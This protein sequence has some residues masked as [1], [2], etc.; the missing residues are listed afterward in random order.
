MLVIMSDEVVGTSTHGFYPPVTRAW[1]R[2]ASTID[3]VFQF[4]GAT[5]AASAMAETRWLPQG[6]TEMIGLSWL[7]AMRSSRCIQSL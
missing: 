4:T 1:W 7:S 5:A 2:I 3:F 6:F